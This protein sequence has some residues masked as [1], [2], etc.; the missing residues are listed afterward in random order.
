MVTR[1]HAIYRNGAF[2]PEGPLSVPDGAKVELTVESADPPAA[3]A[4][5]L[6]KIAD[7]PQGGAE[8][9]FSGADHDRVLYPKRGAR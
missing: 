3:L 7:L 6:D 9:G 8:D 4:A 1:V 2:F 5:A